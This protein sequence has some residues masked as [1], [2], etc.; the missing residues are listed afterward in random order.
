MLTCK[1]VS[2][3]FVVLA[4]LGSRLLNSC[5]MAVCPDGETSALTLLIRNGNISCQNG[6]IV[7]ASHPDSMFQCFLLQEDCAHYLLYD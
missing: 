5:S 1:S 2:L 6:R 4:N 3:I 7:H